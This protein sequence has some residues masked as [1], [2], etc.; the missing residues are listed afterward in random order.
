M[1]PWSTDEQGV[2]LLIVDLEQQD[3]M[4]RMLVPD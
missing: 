1:S 2:A 4:V 3:G